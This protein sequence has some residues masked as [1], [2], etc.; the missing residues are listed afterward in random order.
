MWVSFVPMTISLF[1]LIPLAEYIS[2]E[3]LSRAGMETLLIET[4][5]FHRLLSVACFTLNVVLP[6]STAFF[7]KTPERLQ[8]FHHATDVNSN[9]TLSYFSTFYTQIWT[10][11]RNHHFHRITSPSFHRNRTNT[12]S[13]TSEPLGD[14]SVHRSDIKRQ[15]HCVFNLKALFK[16]VL[17][18]LF[19]SPKS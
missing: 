7:L 6:G 15:I 3:K 8:W 9:A 4:S 18:H 16:S 1:F 17:V 2:S 14:S 19:Y 12:V 13:S 5:Y 10:C 11:L